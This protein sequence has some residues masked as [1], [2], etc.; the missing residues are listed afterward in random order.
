MAKTKV[1]QAGCP[2][3][4]SLS[5][6][7]HSRYERPLLNMATAGLEWS[8]AGGLPVLVPIPG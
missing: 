4:G 3:C 1:T 8:S 6:R 2:D 5:R 7:V